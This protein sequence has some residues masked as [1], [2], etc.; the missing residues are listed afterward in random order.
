MIFGNRVLYG[1]GI[2]NRKDKEKPLVWVQLIFKYILLYFFETRSH[3]LAPTD[4][5]LVILLHLPLE[6]Q[7][8]RWVVGITMP[9]L[10]VLKHVYT[11]LLLLQHPPFLISSDTSVTMIIIWLLSTIPQLKEPRF[12]REMVNSRSQSTREGKYNI[13]VSVTPSKEVLA[14]S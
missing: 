5:E 10:C 8:Y 14:N 11:S 3:Y 7:D 12:L 1:R 2:K 6:C 13:I 4:L 9:G